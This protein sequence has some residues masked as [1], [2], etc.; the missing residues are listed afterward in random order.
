MDHTQQEDDALPAVIEEANALAATLDLGAVS[1]RKV[2]PA[3]HRSAS[4]LPD[5]IST[6]AKPEPN[7]RNGFSPADVCE[8]ST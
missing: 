3:P 1:D 7:N 8:R 5:G 4:N 6:A 2:V